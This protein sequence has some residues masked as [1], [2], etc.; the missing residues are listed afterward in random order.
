M[1]RFLVLSL[2]L[3]LAGAFQAPVPQAATSALR[4][5]EGEIGAQA[6]AG[7]WDPLGIADN[8]SQ[9][10]FDR[11][12]TVEQKHGR[13]SMIA[14][15]GYCVPQYLGTF[16]DVKLAAT[17]SSPTCPTACRRSSRSR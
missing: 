16:G 17:S 14:V 8:I 3:A 4:A 7:Y 13:I 9:E 12:R 6:P 15:V 11:Y 10:Q 5:F 2:V 1:A